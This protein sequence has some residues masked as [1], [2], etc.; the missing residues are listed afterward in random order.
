M[1]RDVRSRI[2]CRSEPSL[3]ASPAAVPARDSLNTRRSIGSTRSSRRP[4][5]SFT[6][7]LPRDNQ[8]GP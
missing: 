8:R 6:I 7:R 5:L 3:P 4:K 1:W 2:R